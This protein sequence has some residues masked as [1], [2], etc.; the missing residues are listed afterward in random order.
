MNVT[1]EMLDKGFK[2]NLYCFLFG[3]IT[4]E[5]GTSIFK[6]A[7]SLY[8]LDLTGSAVIFS[9]ILAVGMLP[10][11]FINMF[12]GVG[13]DRSNK[14]KIMVIC[15]SVS[16]CSMLVFLYIF[17]KIPD[18]LWIFG[19]YSVV[20][21]SIQSVF[22]L[23]VYSSIPNLFSKDNAMKINSDYQA[24]GA[25]VNILGPVLGGILYNSVS[26][27]YILIFEAITFLLSAVS[28]VLY[29]YKKN[30]MQDNNKFFEN[31]KNVYG[32]ISNEK[33]IFYLL[34]I[35]LSI[36]FV[37][38]PLTSVVLPYYAY[39]IMKLPSASLG[40]L[41]AIWSAGII[42]GSL[43]AVAKAIQ[44]KLVRLIF[45][46]LQIQGIVILMWLIPSLLHQYHFAIFVILSVYGIILFIGGG[47]NSAINIPM[48][49]Y[50]QVEVPENIRAS[51][52]GVVNTFVMIAAPI[53]TWLYGLISDNI[54]TEVTVVFSGIMI[55]VVSTLAGGNRKLTE[56][57]AK[58]VTEKK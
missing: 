23:S 47:L 2:R 6:F 32:Y 40:V 51:I 11:I 14:K 46:L 12:A 53:G 54:N 8:I 20:L 13:I 29:L 4:S 25:V 7:L 58:D 41:Q 48:L 57:F 26:F 42:V 22:S 35:V 27:E 3:R 30:V 38:I 45:R 56:F 17:V 10:S 18:N 1:M 21:S 55:L 19:V 5:L 33:V 52:Y 44:K 34:L 50:L 28:E 39:K 43:I 36:N 15:D 49:T 31:L 9:T 37:M 16:A 24:V